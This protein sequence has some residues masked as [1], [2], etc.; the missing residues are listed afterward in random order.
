[1]AGLALYLGW[2]LVGGPLVDY[3]DRW[4][5]LGVDARPTTFLDLYLFP[6]AGA[7][8]AAAGNP[9]VSNPSDPLGR[10]YNYPRVWLSFMRYPAGPG[11]VAGVAVSMAIAAFA[12]LFLC[13]GRLSPGQGVWAALLACSPAVM[14][15]VE[16]GNT[17]QIVFCLVATGIVLGRESSAG[18]RT[19]TAAL[20]L[21]AT[22]LKLY[23]ALA[24]VSW[25]NREWHRSLRRLA[26][27]GLCLLAYLFLFREEVRSVLQAT[28]SGWILSYGVQ[29]P[30]KALVQAAGYY[31]RLDLSM[32]SVGAGFYFLALI[33]GLWAVRQGRRLGK[34]T[35]QEETDDACHWR[36]LRVGAAI[37]LGTFFAG[38]SFDYR[39]LFLLPAFPLLWSLARG[40]SA[41]R[42]GQVGLVALVLSTWPSY[43][44][45][46]WAGFLLNELGGWSLAYVL[47][48]LLMADFTRPRESAGVA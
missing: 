45:A 1:M 36:G 47:L 11:A 48:V 31:Q 43:F 44:N 35:P 12:A 34:T 33:G 38:D 4:R 30:A 6:A 22:V 16:R 3:R 25:V 39:Q 23:P 13:W 42:Y 41:A 24:F 46:G 15:G 37:Y 21:A 7:E 10:P 14:L 5:Q 9:A 19:L 32:L 18:R 27:P 26:G 20:W 29:V 40:G 17:D 8:L 28:G 2:L